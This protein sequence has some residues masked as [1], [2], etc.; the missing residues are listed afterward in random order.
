MKSRKSICNLE[1][2]MKSGN[3]NE[4]SWKSEILSYFEIS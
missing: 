2:D 4:I 1:I 3:Q